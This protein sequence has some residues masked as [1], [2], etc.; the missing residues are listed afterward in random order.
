MTSTRKLALLGAIVAGIGVAAVAVAHGPGAGMGYGPGYGMGYGGGPGACATGPAMM[1][2]MGPGM[3]P[4]TMRGPAAGG[5]SVEDFAK[6]Q[7]Q[8]LAGLKDR[9]GITAEQEAAWN[10]FATQAREHRPGTMGPPAATPGGDWYAARV[11]HMKER[12]ATMEKMQGA[13][14]QLY[15]VLTPAQREAF[16]AGFGPRWGGRS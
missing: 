9:L 1:Q 12:V 14:K 13:Y 4:G 7:E 16:G 11:E 5:A 10:A 3:G 8:R 6:F 15:E 2:G